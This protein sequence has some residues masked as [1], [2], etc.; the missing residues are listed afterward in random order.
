MP[1]YNAKPFEIP[2]ATDA[3]Y[4]DDEIGFFNYQPP[5]PHA[6]LNSPEHNGW[7]LPPEFMPPPDAVSYVLGHFREDVH[8][9][10][11]HDPDHRLYVPLHPMYMATF[12][13][14]CMAHFIWFRTPEGAP[15][16]NR[17]FGV[18]EI[19]PFT[20]GYAYF[21][22]N[23]E[24]NDLVPIEPIYQ[25]DRLVEGLS[26]R[27]F[28]EWERYK[29]PPASADNTDMQRQTGPMYEMQ[30]TLEQFRNPYAGQPM[31]WAEDPAFFFWT[32]E[33]IR[34]WMNEMRPNKDWPTR[35]PERITGWQWARM[36]ER[37]KGV[38]F[39]EAL[40][41]VAVF[42]SKEDGLLGVNTT[43]PGQTNEMPSHRAYRIED[44]NGGVY[45][46]KGQDMLL[47]PL[48]DAYRANGV[49][50]STINEQF[51]CQSCRNIRPC[52]PATGSYHRCCHCYSVA[53]ENGENRSA[54]YKCTYS[55]ECRHCV[56]TIESH[57][58]FVRIVSNLNRPGETRRH[59]G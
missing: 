57:G 53:F 15:W 31:Q 18:E 13:Q 23:P 22:N 56:D 4:W 26:L 42:S 36:L 6:P 47:V 2:S 5:D 52:V 1:N 30:K 48:P 44:P 25:G 46:C 41:R 27:I 24:T 8:G 50:E 21:W 10:D 40:A 51:R 20:E 29:A 54:L 9:V 11:L 39:Y 38:P 37:T 7:G 19:E 3:K 33:I 43:Q 45:W 59:R 16:I 49:P 12:L 55:R 28:R 35:K 17:F 14:I 34:N 32:S 58:E